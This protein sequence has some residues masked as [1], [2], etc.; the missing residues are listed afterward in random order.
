MLLLIA[1][2]CWIR[3]FA[4]GYWPFYFS[5]V[6][7]S[8][9]AKKPLQ[10]KECLKWVCMLPVYPC[11]YWGQSIIV[12]V[13]SF[14]VSNQIVAGSIMVKHMKWILVLSLPL[15]VYYLMRCTHKALW[16]V[17]MTSFD[18]TWPYL[19]CGSCFDKICKIWRY[20]MVCAYLF[21]PSRILLSLWDLSG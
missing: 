6:F 11:P 19:G 10:V 14:V 9:E 15:R 18:S 21:R 3:L 17:I 4:L 5:S 20:W 12:T 2:N 7:D 1:N 13:G 16:G 8:D